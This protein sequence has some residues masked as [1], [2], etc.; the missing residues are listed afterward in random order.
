VVDVQNDFSDPAGSL[1]VRGGEAVVPLLNAEV[2]RAVAAGALVVYTQDWHPPQTPHFTTDGGPWPVHCVAGTWGAAF[3]P[4][5]EV[6]GPIIRKGTSGEDG[7]SGFTMA[8]PETGAERATG[9]ERLLRDHHI[10]T[11]VIGGLATDYCVKETGLDA[12]RAGF[13]AVVLNDAVRAVDVAEGDGDRALRALSDA[14]V[15]IA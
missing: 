13:E 11:V 15:V 1:Y 4:D 10:T 9:L 5:L 3:H 8:E 6:V 7:Y 12:R 2:G 14:G